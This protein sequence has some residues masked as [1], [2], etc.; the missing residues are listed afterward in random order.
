MHTIIICSNDETLTDGYRNEYGETPDGFADAMTDAALC[1]ARLRGRGGCWL[2]VRC[3]SANAVPVRVPQRAF[4]DGLVLL[5]AVGEVVQ[6]AGNFHGRSWFKSGV[7][8]R[9][10]NAYHGLRFPFGRGWEPQRQ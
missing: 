7:V 8:G 4:L 5:D 9:N 2:V 1:D 3:H 6:D 10:G